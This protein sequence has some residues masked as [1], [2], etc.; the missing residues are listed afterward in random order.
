MTDAN[1]CLFV[2]KKKRNIQLR[3]KS[4][5]EDGKKKPKSDSAW[6]TTGSQSNDDDDSDVD[7][8]ESLR[9]IKQ[10]SRKH[11]SN[12]SQST[13]CPKKANSDTETRKD[14]FAT[15]KA[16]T[17]SKRTGPSDMGATATYDLDTEFDK[18]NQAVFERARL[19]NQELKAKQVD[20][21]VYRGLNNYQQF[22]EKKDTAQGNASSGIV[23]SKGPIR[24]P[25]N[26]RA[27]VRW[28]YQPDVCKDYKETGFCGFGDSCKFMHDRS[29]YK[30]GWQLEQEENDDELDE[31]SDDDSDPNKYVIAGVHS[32]DGDDDLPFKCLICRESFVNPVV[33]KCKHY[34]CE[35]CFV[36]NNKKNSRC[37]A[38][39]K[40]TLG[41]FFA[42]KEIIKKMNDIKQQSEPV[43]EKKDSEDSD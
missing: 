25:T 40:Q 22:Y 38:C 19:I 13:K 6:T 3:N 15:F 32:D 30:H 17:G 1:V 21:K 41:I 26:L 11:D 34:F 31:E 14:L 2:K 35:K 23:R 24:A 27:T 43:E 20:D 28:D 37:F 33:T 29:D 8:S 18:D 42:A 4:E 36:Q 16:D 12:L 9:E 39:K 10:K 7:V 5:D